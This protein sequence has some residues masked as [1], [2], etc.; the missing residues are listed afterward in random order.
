MSLTIQ[1]IAKT[2]LKCHHHIVDHVH[3]HIDEHIDEHIVDHVDNQL[4]ILIGLDE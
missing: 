1:V 2:F 3:D 4:D